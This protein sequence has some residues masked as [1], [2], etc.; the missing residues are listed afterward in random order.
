MADI[1]R[2]PEGGGAFVVK[3][4]TT[5]QSWVDPD[6]PLHLEFEYVQRIAEA[7]DA[8]VLARPVE[9]RVR[10]VHIGGGGLTIPRYVEA[11]RPHTAQIVL[12]PDADLIEQV[13]QRLPLPSHSGIKVRTVDGASGVAAMTDGYADAIVLDAFANAQVPGELV[14]SGFFADLARVLRPS[15]LFAANV[16][17]RAPLAWSRRV[18]AGVSQQ[19]PFVLVGAEVPVWKGRRFGNFTI[20]ASRKPLPIS[21]LDRAA[22]RAAFRHRLLWGT[23]L[24]NWIGSAQPFSDDDPQ[25]SPPPGRSWFS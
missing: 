23:E 17:D 18:V 22:M 20:V 7:L 21:E 5:E 2:A 12:E 13:R 1:V 24:A 8:T 6:D 14:T 11:R 19:W 25:P 4:G 9:E 3:A 10:V 16:T 15:G